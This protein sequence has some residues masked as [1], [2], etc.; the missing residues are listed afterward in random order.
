MV[1]A[2]PPALCPPYKPFIAPPR[3]HSDSASEP[4][5]ESRRLQ[6]LRDAHTTSWVL[7]LRRMGRSSRLHHMVMRFAHVLVALVVVAGTMSPLN[8]RATPMPD[9]MVRIAFH[10][11]CQNC[12]QPH[13][14]GSMNPDKMPA[15]PAFLC[16]GAVAMLP[17]PV[18]LPERT[19]LLAVYLMTPPARWIAAPRAPD[20]FPPRPIS[21]I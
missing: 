3:Q 6:L 17:A 20:P 13:Q 8:L 11:P 19:A 2:L 9:G 21:L 15:C 12:P 16:L 18:L 1:L 5:R 7:S 14:T 10:Q 4:R